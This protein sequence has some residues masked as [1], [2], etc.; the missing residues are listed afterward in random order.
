MRRLKG[1]NVPMTIPSD[2]KRL[3]GKLFR[4]KAA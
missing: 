3:F 1:E 4:R 2:P